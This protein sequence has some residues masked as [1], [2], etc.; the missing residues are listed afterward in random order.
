MLYIIFA[1]ILVIKLWLDNDNDDY[2]YVGLLLAM[3]LFKDYEMPVAVFLG[4]LLV[5]ML[6]REYYSKDS[7]LRSLWSLFRKKRKGTKNF[8]EV[9]K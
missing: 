7:I 9:K 8:K 1:L 6:W 4:L 3:V 5:M 2:V